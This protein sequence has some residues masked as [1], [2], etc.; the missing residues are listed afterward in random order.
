MRIFN[1]KLHKRI[2]DLE[3]IIKRI[4]VLA[5]RAHMD[6][7]IEMCKSR[8]THVRFNPISVSEVVEKILNHFGLRIKVEPATEKTFS[9]ERKGVEGV[10]NERKES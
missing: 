10:L 4:N 9:L 7:T 5:H 1:R 2:D 6:S 8:H 3:E